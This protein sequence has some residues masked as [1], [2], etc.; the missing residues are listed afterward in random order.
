M[1]TPDGRSILIAWMQMWKRNMPTR[2]EGWA[3]AMTLPRELSWVD[4][5]LRQR[6]LREL[7]TYR[8]PLSRLENITLSATD[9]ANPASRSD[10]PVGNPLSAIRGLNLELEL[11]LV[12]H[13]A[14]SVSIRLFEGDDR[15]LELSY[16]KATQTI[17]MDRSRS[18]C[19]VRSLDRREPAGPDVRRTRLNGTPSSELQLRIFLDQSSAEVF[20]NDGRA[21]MSMLYYP[22]EGDE[23]FSLH[24]DGK[25]RL[26]RLEAWRIVAPQ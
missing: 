22:L 21:V 1:Q 5:G 10:L 6:P 12:L 3:G 25:A 9:P 17:R 15:Y 26:K 2:A 19:P 7:E 18:G 20:I 24:C 4:G 14:E 11:K 23:G 8:Q 16:E 13:T